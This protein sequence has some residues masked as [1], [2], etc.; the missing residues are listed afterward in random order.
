MYTTLLKK[1]EGSLGLRHFDFGSLNQ[2]WMYT[3]SLSWHQKQYL[4]TLRP[5]V[6]Y[7]QAITTHATSLA[8]RKYLRDEH[9]Y[10]ALTMSAG[11]LP[12]ERRLK[13]EWG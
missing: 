6:I 9:S 2:V 4:I 11:L 12:D 10:L 13:V 1:L 7:N 3:S 8:I 5:S